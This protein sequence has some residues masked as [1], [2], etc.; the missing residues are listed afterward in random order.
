MVFSQGS[1]LHMKNLRFRWLTGRKQGYLSCRKSWLSVANSAISERCKP[2]KFPKPQ[3]W[4]LGFGK[5]GN[6]QNLYVDQTPDCR[7][8][9]MVM[10]H[11]CKTLL[12]QF[13]A[14]YCILFTPT[15]ELFLH[16]A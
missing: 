3:F 9:E 14:I 7:K 6:G 1:F 16:V 8:P 12:W 15:R 5:T 11:F 10:W 2:P 13:Y 4:V